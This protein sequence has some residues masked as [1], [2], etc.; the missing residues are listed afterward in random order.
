MWFISSLTYPCFSDSC[1]LDKINRT[2]SPNT[3]RYCEIPKNRILALQD[4][5]LELLWVEAAGA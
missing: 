4:I 1:I 2:T 5:D 3:S